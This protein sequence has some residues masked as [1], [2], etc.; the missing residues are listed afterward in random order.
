VGRRNPYVLLARKRH[1][2]AHRYRREELEAEVDER[3]IWNEL[4]S[5]VDVDQISSPPL[6]EPEGSKEA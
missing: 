3:E 5:G 1:A 2:G 4:H 6:L